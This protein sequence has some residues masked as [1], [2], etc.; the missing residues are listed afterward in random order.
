MLDRFK[1]I[2]D[3]DVEILFVRDADSRI[4]ARDEWCIREFIQSDKQFHVIRDHPYHTSLIMGGLWGIKK[5]CLPSYMKMADMARAYASSHQNVRGFDQNFLNN[6]IY[7][8]V[9]HVTLFHGMVRMWHD[10]NVIGIP[11]R[12]PHVFC[13]Q[14]IEYDAAGKEYH[15]CNDCKAMNNT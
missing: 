3:P 6:V 5:G 12:T 14:A 15:N 1:P 4:N 8:K 9:A 13:G 2:D 7:P 10:E 11:L